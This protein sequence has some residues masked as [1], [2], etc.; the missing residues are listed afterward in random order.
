LVK[1]REYLT[2]SWGKLLKD[3][4]ADGLWYDFLEIPE[5]ADP[6]KDGAELNS[7]D[8]HEAYTLLLQ[9]LYKTALAANPDVVIILRR[10]IA[11][12]NSK[13]F[14]THVWP[15]DTPQDYNMNRR[16]VVYLKTFGDGVLT[17]AC[18]TSW[19][20]SESD[21]NV[22]RQMASI[23]LAGVPAFSVKLAESPEA[24]N[25]IIRAW[26]KFYEENKEDLMFGAMTPLLPTPPSAAIEIEGKNKAFFG[27]FEAVPGLV[28]VSKQ[29]DSITIVNGFSNRV[30]TKIE[31]VEGNYK[32]E[33][34]D[35]IWKP[36][37]SKLLK[38]DGAGILV[39]CSAPTR[40]FAVKLTK[41]Q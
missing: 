37:S 11:N 26:L 36:T 5:D 35:Q 24:H 9:E 21:E 13:T 6:P 14:A 4:R 25:A 15:M 38:N 28:R 19:P 31:G 7:T 10:G 1:T 2:K 32:A 30:V 20:I 39:D 34:F 23:T 17:H 16:D 3:Y 22:A 27:F 40:C 33:T 18:C 8:L 12:L 29:F 41:E